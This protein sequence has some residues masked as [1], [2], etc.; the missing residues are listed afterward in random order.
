L[1]RPVCNFISLV[2]GYG[3]FVVEVNPLL[4]NLF[5]A[6][7]HKYTAFLTIA[8]CFSTYALACNVSPGVL[9]K[10][11]FLEFDSYSHDELMFYRFV[12]KK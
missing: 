7:W 12:V 6:E 5:A 4:P 10:D 8:A 11:N 1:I 3:L 9:D 2:G